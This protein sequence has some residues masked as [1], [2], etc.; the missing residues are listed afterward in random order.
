MLKSDYPIL[1]TPQIRIETVRC[2]QCGDEFYVG[3]KLSSLTGEYEF[4]F[5]IKLKYKQ[6]HGNFYPASANIALENKI[7]CDNCHEIFYV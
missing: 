5:V 2:P 4:F 7:K 1:N 6:K 3:K